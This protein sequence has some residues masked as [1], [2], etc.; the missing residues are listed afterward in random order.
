MLSS[1]HALQGSGMVEG[2]SP[3]RP[4]PPTLPSFPGTALLWFAV[5]L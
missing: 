4:F 3:E 1:A 2:Q 5:M